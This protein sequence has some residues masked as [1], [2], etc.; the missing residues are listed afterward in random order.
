[1]TVVKYPVC[2]YG[3]EWNR[4]DKDITFVII[5][6]IIIIIMVEVSPCTTVVQKKFMNSICA[7]VFFVALC[8]ACHH[9]ITAWMLV[10]VPNISVF[11]LK[12]FDWN[13]WLSLKYK[14]ILNFTYLKGRSNLNEHLSIWAFFCWQH[15]LSCHN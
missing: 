8:C 10:T 13:L 9:V 7:V 5:I 6:V 15:M 2:S 11:Q 12:K 4:H 14:T 3:M 1:M